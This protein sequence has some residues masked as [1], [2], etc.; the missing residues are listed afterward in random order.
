MHEKTGH[1]V[2]SMHQAKPELP[3]P[4]RGSLA[5]KADSP[6]VREPSRVDVRTSET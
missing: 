2:A 4:E 5:A 3:L 1:V 6:D